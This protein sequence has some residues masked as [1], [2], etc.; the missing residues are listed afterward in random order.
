MSDNPLFKPFF[1]VVACSKCDQHAW[2]T[3]HNEAKYAASKKAVI[4]AINVVLPGLDKSQI[5]NGVVPENYCDSQQVTLNN[6]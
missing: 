1:V 6:G 3:R 4:D 5:I 2:C